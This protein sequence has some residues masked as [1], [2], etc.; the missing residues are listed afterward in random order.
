LIRCPGSDARRTGSNFA[1]KLKSVKLTERQPQSLTKLG[2]VHE[3]IL[4]NHPVI[5]GSGKP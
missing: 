5:K 3:R 1:E 2:L 4:F